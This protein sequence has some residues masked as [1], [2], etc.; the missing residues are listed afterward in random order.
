MLDV[1]TKLHKFMPACA[2]VN[3]I[4]AFLTINT[5]VRIE[6]KNI[7]L[8]GTGTIRQRML[9]PRT[10]H[11]RMTRP[12]TYFLTFFGPVL[13][14]PERVTTNRTPPTHELVGL[15]PK[16]NLTLEMVGHN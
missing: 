3:Y 12:S 8:T 1:H 13:F 9:C 14:I 2:I 16:P 10:F 6:I 4:F 15:E 7:P 11:P 5:E